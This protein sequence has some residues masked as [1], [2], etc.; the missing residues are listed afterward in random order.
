MNEESKPMPKIIRKPPRR[1]HDDYAERFDAT[2][3][4][5]L[6][7]ECLT[8]PVHKEQIKVGDKMETVESLWCLECRIKLDDIEDATKEAN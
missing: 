7:F 2:V 1:K 4:K 6:C 3:G 5:G 8:R